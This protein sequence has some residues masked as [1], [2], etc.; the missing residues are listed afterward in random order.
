M[1]KSTRRRGG[2]HGSSEAGRTVLAQGREHGGD[3]F[4]AEAVH[5]VAPDGGAVLVDDGGADAFE[6]LAVGAGAGGEA[7]LAGER[8]RDAGVAAGGAD[9]L[10]RAGHGEGALAAE[11]L[12]GCRGPSRRSRAGR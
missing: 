5:G 12:R 9:E 8:L 2:A 6:E 7:V 1:G 3:L 10:E 11:G 4:G